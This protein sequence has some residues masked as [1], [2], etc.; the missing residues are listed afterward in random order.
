MLAKKMAVVV[1][2]AILLMVV[3]AFASEQV[4]AQGTHDPGITILEAKTRFWMR[5][6]V[7]P[8]QGVEFRQVTFSFDSGESTNTDWGEVVA[9]PE[10][11]KES[12][13]YLKL[14]IVAKNAGIGLKR[15]R[16]FIGLGRVVNLILRPVST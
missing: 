16:F 10:R 8:N 1:L 9:D 15:G 2:A 4:S 12:T 6:L 5:Y 13:A 14:K 11:L 3:G 7:K